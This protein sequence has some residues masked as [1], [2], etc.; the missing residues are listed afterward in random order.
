MNSK[1]P[2]GA[3]KLK[4]LEKTEKKHQS[5][6]LKKH[7][8]LRQKMHQQKRKKQRR[9]N[10]ESLLSDFKNEELLNYLRKQLPMSNLP[11]QPFNHKKTYTN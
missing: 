3:R 4:S 1:E 8:Y 2:S 9:Q 6:P 10:R 11:N 5:W 7:S